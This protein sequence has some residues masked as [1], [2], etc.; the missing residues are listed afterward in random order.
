MIF[1]TVFT[2]FCSIA[3]CFL[4][5]EGHY[6]FFSSQSHGNLFQVEVRKETKYVSYYPIGTVITSVVFDPSKEQGYYFDTPSYEG[7]LLFLMQIPRLDQPAQ[8]NHH[9]YIGL[10]VA[11]VIILFILCI[12]VI[13]LLL[14]RTTSQNKKDSAG[15]MNKTL[16]DNDHAQIL[17]IRNYAWSIDMA[18]LR[19]DKL[20]HEGPLGKTYFGVCIYE[21]LICVIS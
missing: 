14:K 16:L 17:N 8:R 19:I 12:C 1:N 18:D 6:A 13:L 11:T 20:L 21:A 5:D 7:S 9:L 10:S 3:S 2:L 15:T 4:D